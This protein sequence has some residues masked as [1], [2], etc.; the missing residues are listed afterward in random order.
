MQ[1]A[2]TSVELIIILA[3]S[4]VVLIA[5]FSYAN[6][7]I[8]DFN[9]QKIVDEAQT[10]VNTLSLAA[11]D[12][13]R[14]GV[15]AKK[16]VFYTVPSGIDESSSG[17][18]S[19]SFV[20]NVLETDVYAKPSVC[21]QGTMPTTKGGHWIWLTAQEECVF[22]GEENIS[23][24]KTASYVTM[25]QDSSED[26]TITITNDG[27]ATATVFITT[28]WSHSNVT[29][30]VSPS[31]FS[32]AA[33]ASQEIT[34][35]YTSNSSASGNYAGTLSI[36]AAFAS[37][38]ENVSVPVNAEVTAPQGGSDLAVFPA[39]RSQNF[40]ASDVDNN[41]FQVCNN[42]DSVLGEI[43][44]SDS[45]DIADWI[46]AIPSFPSLGVGDCN[47]SVNYALTVPG[48]QADGTYTGTITATDGTYS[49]TL[50]LTA[51]VATSLDS[52]CFAF[53]W[54]T[55]SFSRGGD[56]LEDWTIENTCG[57]TITITQMK[58]REWSVNDNDDAQMDKIKLNNNTGW[59]GT[60]D[61]EDIW[62]DIDA[63]FDI[64]A[65]TSYSNNN[66]LEFDEDIDDDGEDFYII[67]GFSDGSNYTTLT[68]DP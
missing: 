61:D 44:F 6:I 51:I 54:S 35:T 19:D 28:T 14:Q 66:K 42:G 34:L 47:S 20:L 68:Y 1:K 33:N 32:L 18:E 22:V 16:K 49:D 67:F 63:D 65:S 59:T 5:I 4:L 27:S 30:G 12:V 57:S 24:D 46:D 2:Q 13:Y 38:D 11:D 25:Q 64:A 29:L 53:D 43:S 3:V 58:V 17:I 10:S 7:S 62:R 26:D 15:G 23:I 8:A 55:A 37:G 60:V 50:D 56:K 52:D 9:Q 45:G 39:T 41:T 31:S 21:L 48:G 40:E 36:G